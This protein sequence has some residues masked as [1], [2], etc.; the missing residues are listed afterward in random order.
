[1][2]KFSGNKWEFINFICIIGLG[3][4]T[5]LGK[6]IGTRWQAQLGATLVML[7]DPSWDTNSLPHSAP[8]LGPIGPLGQ[9][10]V[11]HILPYGLI[12]VQRQPFGQL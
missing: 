8:S 5:Y 10:D 3:E 6:G 1:M 12:C 11:G 2:Y 9:E 4:W 7:T